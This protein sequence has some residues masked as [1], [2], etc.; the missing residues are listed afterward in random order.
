MEK[1]IAISTNTEDTN[2]FIATNIDMLQT[3]KEVNTEYLSQ[4][5][6]IANVTATAHSDMKNL[7]PRNGYFW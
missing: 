4:I 7:K 1:I 2:V 5:E 3:E 6:S